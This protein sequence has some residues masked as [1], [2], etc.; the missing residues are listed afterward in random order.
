MPLYMNA[1]G[2]LIV[3]ASQHEG[4]PNLVKVALARDLPIVSV[5]AGD[6]RERIRGVDNC[7]ICEQDAPEFLTEALL[8]VIKLTQRP[9]LRYLATHL[10]A[11]AVARQT[12]Q[13]YERVLSRSA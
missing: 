11:S 3:V 7:I 2:V 4:S 5:D 12:I 10:N 8:Q 1:C 6:I 9:A 13:V